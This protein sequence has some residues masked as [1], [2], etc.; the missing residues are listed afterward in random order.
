MNV[1]VKKII[2]LIFFVRLFFLKKNILIYEYEIFLY[3][4]DYKRYKIKFFSKKFI[5]VVIKCCV[6]VFFWIL[7]LFWKNN[8]KVFFFLVN[9]MELNFVLEVI[10][11]IIKVK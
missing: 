7:N 11:Y 9:I 3:F 10:N 8:E 2:E 1:D 4:M 6:L 5:I